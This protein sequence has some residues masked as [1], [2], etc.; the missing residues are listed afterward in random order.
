MRRQVRFTVVLGVA[1]AGATLTAQ[2]T[3]ARK[4]W[5]PPLTADGQPNLQGIWT[6]ATITPFERPEIGRA[7]V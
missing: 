6:N 2:S 5:T 3:G 4:T 7:H 1:L